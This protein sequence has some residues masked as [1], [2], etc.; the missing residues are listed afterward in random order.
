MK[1]WKELYNSKLTTADEAVKL[2]KSGDKVVF[3]HDVGEPEELVR[4]MVRNASEYRNVEI[5]HMFSLGPGEY[6]KPEYKDNFHLNMWFLSGQTRNATNQYGDYTSVFFHELPQL[7]RKGVIK[8]DVALVMVSPPDRHGFVSTGVSGDYTIQAIK[9][10]KTVIVQV[11]KNMPFTYGDAVFP[12]MK[13]ADAIVEY[14]EELPALPAAKIGDVEEEIGKNCASLI[15]DGATLQLGIGSIPDAVCEQLMHKRH[16]GLHSEM[17]GDG[18]V[19]LFHEG[20][21]DNS[22]KA[23]DTGLMVANFV[24]GSKELYEF[25][26]HNPTVRLMPV[27]YVNHPAIIMNHK[28]MVAINGALGVDLYGQVASDAMGGHKQFSGVG[29][30]VDF[31]R[32]AAMATDGNG[33]SIIA[34]PSMTVKKDGTKISK[35]SAQL[36]DGQVITDSRN[37]TRYVITE[38]GIAD[39]WGKTNADKARALIDVAHPDFRAELKDQMEEMFRQRY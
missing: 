25:C 28:N 11:N 2:I 9:S 12:L 19:K 4:A 21:I 14:D 6:C 10:A 18:A 20:V 26:D 3:Q 22:E 35:I 17:L 39:L 23:F 8:V 37:D 13:Y 36:A 1:N 24:M 5:S 7:M 15:V 31:M 34:M 29:G 27:D 38:Y 30:Q 33:V 16:L 32:G